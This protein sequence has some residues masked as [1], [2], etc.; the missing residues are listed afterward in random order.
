MRKIFTNT[1]CFSSNSSSN[2]SDLITAGWVYILTQIHD[3]FQHNSESWISSASCVPFPSPATAGQQWLHSTVFPFR[4]GFTTHTHL[5]PSFPKALACSMFIQHW[6]CSVGGGVLLAV[7]VFTVLTVFPS[8]NIA[9]IIKFRELYLEVR[10]KVSFIVMCFHCSYNKTLECVVMMGRPLYKYVHMTI[11]SHA[12][13]N[14]EKYTTTSN[15][16]K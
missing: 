6:L 5:N 16:N 10:S 12:P 4:F 11:H 14:Y 2:S 9:L 7:A 1:C 3:S 8:V 15:K 13:N